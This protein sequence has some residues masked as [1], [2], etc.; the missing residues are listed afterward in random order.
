[1][2]PVARSQLTGSAAHSR[3]GR[4]KEPICPAGLSATRQILVF[5]G[6]FPHVPLHRLIRHVLGLVASF[7]G[8]FAPVL[9]VVEDG[10]DV[11]TRFPFWP[12]VVRVS[13]VPKDRPQFAAS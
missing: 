12:N 11:R 1:M 2:A 6:N 4:P 5:I 9:Y 13:D 10:H 8:A 3:T 7:L